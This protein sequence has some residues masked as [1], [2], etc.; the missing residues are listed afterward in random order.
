M[1]GDPQE[2][3]V[4]PKA[5]TPTPRLLA[6]CALLVAAASQLRAEECCDPNGPFALGEEYPEQPASCETIASW[7]DRA[8]A[9]SDRISLGIRDRLAAVESDAALAY[10][11]MCAPPGIQVLCVTYSRGSLQPGDVVLFGG[12]YS[13]HG[14]KQIVLDPCLA[15]RE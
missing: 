9:T 8:P 10:L 5:R 11:V 2:F 14:E 15:S 13:R 12:G 6:L 3:S 1:P 7:A 4:M